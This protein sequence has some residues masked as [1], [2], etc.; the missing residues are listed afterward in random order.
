MP[1]SREEKRLAKLAKETEKRKRML[2]AQ[3]RKTPIVQVACERLSIGRSTYYEWRRDDRIF[4][5]AADRALDHGRTFVN[6]LAE[7]KLIA[8]I[9]D[10]HLPA[11]SLWLK[12]N[13]SRYAVT[14]RTIYDHDVAFERPSTEEV[15]AAILTLQMSM[16]RQLPPGMDREQ[17]ID[18]EREKLAEYDK[19]P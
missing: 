17:A 11:I 15:N 16:L 8:L 1:M 3:L 5:R 12:H 7:S 6:D 18:E 9:K 4:A 19:D 2:V 14:T 13:N 10:G